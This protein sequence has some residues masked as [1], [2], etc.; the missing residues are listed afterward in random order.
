MRRFAIGEAQCIHTRTHTHNCSVMAKLK[1]QQPLVSL[2]CHVIRDG[3]YLK[4]IYLQYVF[5][6]QMYVMY[7]VFKYIKFLYFQNT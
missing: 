1:F 5:E 6:I 4:C 3:Q 7:F 2:Q